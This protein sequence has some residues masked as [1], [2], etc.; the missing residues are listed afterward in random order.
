MSELIER[1]EAHRV[2][3]RRLGVRRVG[4]FGSWARGEARPDSDVDVLV[5]FEPSQKTLSNLVAL[6]DLLEKLFNRRVELVTP[7]S[8]SPYFGH[9]ILKQVKYADLT[10]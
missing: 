5:E 1:V 8:L 3:L 2:E 4:I 10:H 7:E 9:E 6:G